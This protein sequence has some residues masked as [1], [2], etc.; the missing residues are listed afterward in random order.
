MK[1]IYEK[2][3]RWVDSED[4]HLIEDDNNNDNENDCEDDTKYIIIFL[5]QV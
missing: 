5:L 3:H 4:D 1:E 2:S